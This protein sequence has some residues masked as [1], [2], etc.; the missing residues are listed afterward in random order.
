MRWTELSCNVDTLL[1]SLI[2]NVNVLRFFLNI[3]ETSFLL[4]ALYIICIGAL[5]I[6]NRHRLKY[7]I[8][9]SVTIKSYCTFWGVCLFYFLVTCCIFTYEFTVFL[10]FLVAVSIA[11]L[12]IGFDK[13]KIRHLFFLVLFIN[14]VYSILI[15]SDI[16][17]VNSYM[18]GSANYL[19]MTLTLGLC[20]SLC[21]SSVVLIIL[22]KIS[23]RII[24]FIALTFIF[25]PAILRFPARGV[26][27][28]PPLIAIVIA[29]LN[30]R[31]QKLMLIS[32]LM[33]LAFVIA[34]GAYYFIQNASEYALVHM[35]NLF[36]NIE[37]ESR[38]GLWI[39]V[40]DAIFQN[41]WVFVGAG[42]NGFTATMG[43]YPHN[44]FLHFLADTG[45]IGCLGF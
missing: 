41:Y 4:Y 24:L 34:I 37:D 6:T 15:V 2:I 9:N 23:N 3:D 21:M 25:F 40:F 13:R 11:I 33:G 16:D 1:L 27:L 35:A 22:H 45:F 8:K 26:M 7:R 20:L 38:V 17:R 18:S 43:F 36:E 5:Y 14:L 12:C 39:K 30:G 19:N 28:F 31:K 10:K 32:I 44:V 29:L 42:L